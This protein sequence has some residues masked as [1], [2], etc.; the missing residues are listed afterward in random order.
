MSLADPA[1]VMRRL[2]EIEGDLALR[3]GAWEEAAQ[4]HYLAKR[5][6]EKRRAEAFLTAE[7][8]VAERSAIADKAAAMIGN[9]EEAA[10]EAQKSV[11]RVLET[12]ANIG[13]S[14]LRV[15]GRGA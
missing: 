5:E 13:M 7:G 4:A 3:Q 10:Y 9:V 2:A 8:T 12:R 15:Q 14:I 1:S 6:K 11:V